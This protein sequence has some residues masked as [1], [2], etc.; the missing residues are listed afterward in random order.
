MLATLCLLESH[1]YSDR[2]IGSRP[3]PDCTVRG[4]DLLAG[5]RLDTGM[6]GFEELAGDLKVLR[7]FN[8]VGHV[9]ARE[10]LE[11]L[12]LLFCTIRGVNVIEVGLDCNTKRNIR[13]AQERKPTKKGRLDY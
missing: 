13:I 11:F 6:D 5:I 3:V 1:S 12:G 9:G 8:S 2:K 7:E 10:E 4:R